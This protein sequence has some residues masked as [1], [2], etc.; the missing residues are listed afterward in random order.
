MSTTVATAKWIRMLRWVRRTWITPSKAQ[1]RLWMTAGVRRTLIQREFAPGAPSPPRGRS[2]GGE[3]AHGRAARARPRRRPAGRGRRRRAGAARRPAA[4]RGRRW[5]TRARR[6]ARRRRG[7][8]ASG[9][10]CARAARRR[11]PGRPPRRPRPRAPPGTPRRRPPRR[12]AG[13]SGCRSRRGSPAALRAGLL[14]M[15]LVR[16]DDA[17]D[18]H[19]TDDVLVAELD[20]LDAVD[21]RQDAAHVDEARRLILREVDLRDVSG[22]DDLRAEAEPREKHLHLLRRRVLRL[23]QDD[24]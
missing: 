17:L 21:L 23:V 1:F 18:E 2:R 12:P 8:P 16:L 15:A 24:E 14:R 9:R 22:D 20:E 7:A 10:A 3:G 4:R 6:S 13:R 5:G 19:V 11:R